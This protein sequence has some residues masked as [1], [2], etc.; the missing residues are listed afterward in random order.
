[1]KN[2]LSDTDYTKG[3]DNRFGVSVVVGK[4][5]KIEVSEKGANV[6][7]IMKDRV[8]H[9]DKPL[10]TKPIPVLQIASQAKK[11]FAVPRVNDNVFMVKMPNGTSNYVVIGSFYTSKDPP[12]VTDP[13]LD[14]VIYDDGSTMQ[15]NAE[16]GELTWK[17]KGDMLWD[18]E[19]DF[20]LKTKGNVKV[21]IDGDITLK[22]DGKVTIE[23]GSDV[24][25]KGANVKLEGNLNFQGNITHTGNMT[26]SGIH[27]DS[28]G[29]HTGGAG[30]MMFE[31]LTVANTEEWKWT[32]DRD[33]A[34]N[35]GQ[36][37]LDAESWLAAMT[38][39]LSMITNTSRDMTIV[40]NELLTIGNELLLQ[41]KADSTRFG[42][43]TI[44]GET[45][46]HG[47]WWQLPVRYI[48]G[49]GAV[50]ANNAA[51][52]VTLIQKANVL[53]KGRIDELE[54]R[55]AQLEARHGH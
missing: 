32:T 36:V 51:T 45:A 53:A 21:E 1:M 47:G 37:G 19:K 8:D 44:I 6:R 50:P 23:A 28:L 39:N 46:Q 40:F 29:R 2:I 27:T 22:P 31:S 43:Y 13:K 34:A 25:V 10:I 4:V 30:M 7:V 38:I 15:F 24:L 9:Q 54:R 48:D 18:N 55:L 3:W 20:T 17:I 42:H 41:A 26:T 52:T 35:A 33:D 5:S 49:N 14:Y 12:P 11:S 16:T